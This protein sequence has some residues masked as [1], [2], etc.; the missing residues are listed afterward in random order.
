M[1]IIKA[2]PALR[3]NLKKIKRISSVVTTPYDVISKHQQSQ[4]YRSN[5][6]NLIRIILGKEK[7]GD[8]QQNNKYTRAGACLDKWIEEGVFIQDDAPAIYIYQQLFDS[9]RKKVSRLGFIALLKLEPPGKGVVFP[10][11]KTFCKPKED[12]LS[13]LKSTRANLSP[14]FGLYS[15]PDSKIENLIKNKCRNKPLLDFEFEQVQNRLWMITDPDFIIKLEEMTGSKKIFIADGHHR[16]EVACLYDKLT[17]KSQKAVKPRRA[18]EPRKLNSAYIMMYFS[19]LESRGL[20]VLPTHRVINNLPDVKLCSLKQALAD[21]FIIEDFNNYKDLSQRL[22][23]AKTSEHFFGMYLGNKIFYL[24]KLKKTTKKTARHTRGTYKDLD[25][26]IL[27]SLIFKK[28]L[29]IKEE[30]SRDQQILYTREENLAIQLVNSKKY[31]AAFFM[32]PPRPRQISAISESL[33]KMPHK[34]TYFYPKPLSGLVI[35]KLAMES[36][37]HVAF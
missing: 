33:Q 36:E 35:N 5:K 26:V 10:H 2:F 37:A 18:A 28:I 27:H 30:N 20:K 1:A 16:Y 17:G 12:R 32:N 9:E 25:V 4:F 3:Y 29:G 21:Y 8:D 24:L 11:E 23:S 19:A 6:Y 22:T 7:T 34:S 31:Q 14:I 15:D 13:L